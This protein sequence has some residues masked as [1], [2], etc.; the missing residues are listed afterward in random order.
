VGVIII[1]GIDN[2]NNNMPQSQNVRRKKKVVVVRSK[3]DLTGRVDLLA[4]GIFN[5]AATAIENKLQLPGL[6]QSLKPLVHKHVGEQIGR[7]FNVPKEYLPIMKLIGGKL[8][9]S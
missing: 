5:F 1:E 8:N 3:E 4:L 7:D 9:V 6:A 2:N